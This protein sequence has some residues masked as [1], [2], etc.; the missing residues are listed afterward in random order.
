MMMVACLQKLVVGSLSVNLNHA[1]AHLLVFV[2]LE[3]L[4][5]SMVSRCKSYDDA[6]ATTPPISKAR[7]K[8]IWHI[9]YVCTCVLKYK[10]YLN[11]WGPSLVREVMTT[12]KKPYTQCGLPF[13]RF[14]R[15]MCRNISPKRVAPY[16]LP[17]GRVDK[18]L[19]RCKE[20]RP[21]IAPT[22]AIP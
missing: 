9:C 4:I 7:P 3:V 14:A 16:G 2:L 22:V 15:R 6:V 8:T 19:R 12:L 21:T 5:M 13:C 18:G 20:L 11:P 17:N 10:L 1:R